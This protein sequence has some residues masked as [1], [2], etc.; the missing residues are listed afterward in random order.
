MCST[1]KIHLFAKSVSTSDTY[2]RFRM[3]YSSFHSTSKLLLFWCNVRF[4]CPWKLLHLPGFIRLLF[5]NINLIH[6]YLLIIGSLW[7][8]S[9]KSQ[10]RHDIHCLW[11]SEFFEIR[12]LPQLN[13]FTWNNPVY[14]WMCKYF[15]ELDTV[16]SEKQF[17]EE[18]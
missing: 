1:R 7:I 3:L 4:S 17:G 16:C 13:F 6:L 10:K 15:P 12:I 11:E 2:C 9:E 14:D 18:S 5:G 8:I